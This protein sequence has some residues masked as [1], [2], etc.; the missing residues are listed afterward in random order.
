MLIVDSL[1]LSESRSQA[2]HRGLVNDACIITDSGMKASTFQLSP[3]WFRAIEEASVTGAGSIDMVDIAVL[4][5]SQKS[6]FLRPAGDEMAADRARAM[7]EY[8]GSDHITLLNAFRQFEKAY[9]KSESDVNFSL[10]DWCK[11]HYLDLDV[12]AEALDARVNVSRRVASTKLRAS[13]SLMSSPG[14]I[15]AIARAFSNQ[16]AYFDGNNY[17]T[18]NTHVMARVPPHSSLL[19]RS[20]AW[21]VYTK[22]SM[23]GQSVEMDAVSMI[24]LD[25]LLVSI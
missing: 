4:C 11:K 17:R 10:S 6:I 18:V 7:F 25:W 3:P 21:V 22:L 12:L 24:S 5:S 8:G 19:R 16:I 9:D 2:M 20:A 1:T 14:L 13:T 23:P 15:K